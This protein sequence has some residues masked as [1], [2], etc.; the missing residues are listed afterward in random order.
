MY[1]VVFRVRIKALDGDYH[2]AI[3]VWISS[4]G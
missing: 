2:A 3:Q 1:V 4:P